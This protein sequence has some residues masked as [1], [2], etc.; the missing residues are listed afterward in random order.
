[1]TCAINSIKL[2]IVILFKPA[3]GARGERNGKQGKPFAAFTGA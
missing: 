1:L 2:V 3:G